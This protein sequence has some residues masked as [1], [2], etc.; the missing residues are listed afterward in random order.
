MGDEVKFPRGELVW[1][2]VFE[3]GRLKYVVTSKPAR[4][5]YFLYEVRNGVLSKIK[6]AK[7]PAELISSMEV[8]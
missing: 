5:F 6:K 1:E 4:D 2:Q 7:S 3:R 8:R